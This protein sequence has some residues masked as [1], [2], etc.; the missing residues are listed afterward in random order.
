L[1]LKPLSKPRNKLVIEHMDFARRIAA[2]VHRRIPPFIQLEDLQQEAFVGLIK[3]AR[4]YNFKSG[5]PFQGFA[6]RKVHG[7]VIDSIRRKNFFE[8]SMYQLLD[9]VDDLELLQFDAETPITQGHDHGVVTREVQRAVASLPAE[10]RKVIELRFGEGLTG[11]AAAERMG[12][13]Y[14]VSSLRKKTAIKN[15]KRRLEGSP[16][17]EE[18][19]RAA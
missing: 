12:V 7:A 5:V 1:T 10:D 14:C 13:G 9:Y 16:H 19:K 4:K 15:L 2:V 8:S 17:F 11:R 6:Y 3:A 18:L